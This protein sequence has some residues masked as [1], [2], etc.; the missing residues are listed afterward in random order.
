MVRLMTE[1]SQ[2]IVLIVDDEPQV[3]TITRMALA[4]FEFEGRGLGFLEAETAREALDILSQPC[5]VALI[6]AGIALE[7]K[8]AGLELARLVR[9]RLGDHRVR[10]VLQIGHPGQAPERDVVRGLDLSDYIDRT[11]LSVHRLEMTVLAGLRSFRDLKKIE[12]ARRELDGLRT[13]LARTER[14][15]RLQRALFAIADLAG[16]DRDMP[17]VL[18][19]IHAIV[20]SLMHSENFYIVQHDPERETLRFLYFV[21]SEDDGLIDSH[22]HVPMSSRKRSLTWYLLRDG[23]TLMGNT[24][25]LREQVSGPLAIIGAPPQDWLGVPMLRDGRARG[26]VVVQSYLE[27]IGYSVDDRA[28]LEFVAGHILNALERKQ[29]KQELEE[30]V[31]RRTLELQ[32]EV[33]E[34]QR[35]ERLQSALFQIAQLAAADIDQVEFCRRVHAAVAGLMNAENFFIAFLAEDGLT[36]EFP[37]AI[38][39]TGEPYPARPLGHGLSEY[40]LRHGKAIFRDVDILA[41]AKSGEA[42]LET[43]GAVS[44]WWLGVPLLLGDEAIG[45]IAVQSYD[46]NLSYGPADQD[47]L[48]F[49]A[50]QVGNSLQRR[51]YTEALRREYSDLDRRQRDRFG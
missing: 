3:R 33:A 27:G 4:R 48:A 21:D 26:A 24:A 29:G 45:L 46:A 41:L 47:L 16:S 44:A 17:E 36:L 1:N 13:S 11:G 30:Q 2:W 34:R 5:D 39:R 51:R 18:R 19:G 9:E 7:T 25:Q 38:D 23:K 40:V 14:S 42:D 28:L 49:V 43:V 10:I 6:L 12:S 35:G 32:E 50:T 15:E 31:R 37:Y 20:G 22:L 8:D